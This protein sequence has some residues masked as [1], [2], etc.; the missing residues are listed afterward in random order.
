M[1]IRQTK[2]IDLITDLE[3]RGHTIDIHNKFVEKYGGCQNFDEY[4]RDPNKT[5]WIM[6]KS[7]AIRVISLV[8]LFKIKEKRFHQR[9]TEKDLEDMESISNYIKVKKTT[10][11]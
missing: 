5:F 8:E 4:I 2:D 7:K 6:H 9:G 10:N 3:H 1:G 11:L